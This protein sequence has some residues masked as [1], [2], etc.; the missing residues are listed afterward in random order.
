MK[1]P[2]HQDAQFGRRYDDSGEDA[3]GSLSRSDYRERHI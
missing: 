2:L 1:L 3:L